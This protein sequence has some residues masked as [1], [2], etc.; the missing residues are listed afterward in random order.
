MAASKSEFIELLLQVATPLPFLVVCS[1]SQQLIKSQVPKQVSQTAAF[2]VKHVLC[3][4]KIAGSA[5]T[6]SQAR[7]SHEMANTQELR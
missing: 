5:L 1:C 3:T 7:P 6:E 2:P 4:Q